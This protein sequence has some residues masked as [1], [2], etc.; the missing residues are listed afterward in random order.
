M[1]PAPPYISDDWSFDEWLPLSLQMHAALHFTPID[2]SR[3]AASVLAPEPGMTVLDVGAGAGKF[4]IAAAQAAPWAEFVGVEWRPH[5]VRIAE[6]L[7]RAYGLS[8]VRFVH[9]DAFDLD[10]SSFDAFYLYNPFAEQLL[11]SAFVLDETIAFNP[12]NFALFVDLVR[13]RLARARLGTRV[14]TYHG[15]GAPP[16]LGYEL[17]HDD[18]MGTDRVELWVKAREIVEARDSEA[19][20]A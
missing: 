14:A 12:V 15:F 11:D 9:A 8:N 2:V 18:A 6:R 13:E 10:W 17:L 1:E 5:L 20:A 3:H 7:A 16:P 4:C 19:E